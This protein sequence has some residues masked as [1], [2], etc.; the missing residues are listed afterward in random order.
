MPALM[1]LRIRACH[2]RGSFVAKDNQ[3]PA[4]S[5][6]QLMTQPARFDY[7]R[8]A[9][10]PV[11]FGHEKLKYQ[12]R[13]PAARRY[14]EAHG[15]NEFFAGEHAEFSKEAAALLLEVGIIKA[16]PDLSKLADTRFLK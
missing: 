11:T 15:L 1:E 10:P 12:E 7:N 16:I 2:V 9:H 14:I 4:I 3:A 6:R 5:T 8:L 13:L